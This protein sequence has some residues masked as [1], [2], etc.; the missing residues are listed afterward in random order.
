LATRSKILRQACE[1]LA[2]PAQGR[3][4][5]D[6][7]SAKR[8]AAPDLADD[9]NAL[10]VQYS[11]DEDITWFLLVMIW[12]GQIVG[13]IDETKRFALSASSK[14]SRIAAFRALKA[15]GSEQDRLDVRVAILQETGELDRDWVAEL[16]LWLPPDEGAVTWLVE[17]LKRVAPPKQFSVDSLSHAVARHSSEWPVGLLNRIVIEFSELMEMP[18]LK[19]IYP[20]T[21]SERFSWLTTPAASIMLAIIGKRELGAIDSAA[22]SLLR[23]IPILQDAGELD[24]KDVITELRTQIAGWPELN[25]KL[26]W[27]GVE[28]SREFMCARGYLQQGLTLFHQVDVSGHLW[29]YSEADFEAV[30]NEIASREMA[31]DRKVALSLA[32]SLYRS[33]ESPSA[34]LEMITT[35]CGNDEHLR[36]MLDHL[37]NPPTGDNDVWIA[38]HASW[39]RKSAR[40]KA[41]LEG[42]K[43][44]WTEGLQKEVDL[45]RSPPEPGQLNNRQLYLL[46]RLQEVSKHSGNWSDRTWEDLIPEVGEAVASAFRDGAIK[47]WRVYTPQLRSEGAALNSTLYSVILGLVGLSFE[48]RINAEWFVGLSAAQASLATRYALHELNGFPGWLPG[49]YNAHREAVLDIL[50][51]EIQFELS[52]KNPKENS[53]Y[54]LNDISSGGDWIWDGLATRLIYELKSSPKDVTRLRNIL[55]ILQG[56]TLS[57]CVLVGL[58]AKKAKS[59]KGI[60]IASIW[61]A[62]WVGVAPE[63]AIPSLAARLGSIE[64]EESRTRFAMLF[65]TALMG[66][67]RQRRAVRDAFRTVEH[68]KALYLLMNTYIHEQDDIDRANSGVYSPELRDDAQDAR[69]ALLSFIRETP[70]KEAFLTLMEISQSHPNAKSRPWL[71][72]QAKAKATLEANMAPWLPQQVRD[73]H[74]RQERTPADHRGLWDLAVSQLQDLKHDLEH[75]DSSIASI[76]QPMNQETEIRK[77]IGGWCRKWARGRYVI[78]QEEEFADAKRADLRFH[79][80]GFDAQVPVELKLADKWSGPRLEERL[81]NQLCGDYMRD[82]RSRYGIFL[83]VYHGTKPGRSWMM[84][85]GTTALT[86]EALV[87]K[88][89]SR[90]SDLATSYPHIEDILVIG[91]DLTTRG[92]PVQPSSK[93]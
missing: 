86:F 57:D 73:F 83:L 55:N 45:L 19:E 6:I 8:F 49:L 89:Q 40:R 41:V 56:S 88:L 64:Q 90:W 75:G 22:L 9:I 66:S 59:A 62:L 47:H 24:T 67:R 33:S 52:S 2:Q 7:D 70:G 50:M 85:D 31:D 11:D 38:Q 68:M 54:V 29:S 10:L 71:A 65:I 27:Y 80:A 79:G 1:Q 58:A 20:G 35:S 36:A 17:A 82:E 14:Y 21:L 63:E 93:Q 91:I 51:G 48:A 18:P 34:L 69:N 32:F 53:H 16:V 92:A 12:H 87:N 76:L 37:I 46:E 77:F 44:Q 26:F 74:D 78:P 30:C 81:Q 15:I 84:S 61:F 28:R 4:L 23:K 5:I 39:Q 42:R 13:A 25:Q 3:S 72:L 60:E 43:R